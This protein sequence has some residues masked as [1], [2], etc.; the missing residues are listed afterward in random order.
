MIRLDRD[1]VGAN[2]RRSLH[3]LRLVHANQ[4]TQHGQSAGRFNDAQVLQGLRGHLPQRFPGHQRLCPGLLR[5]GQ[6]NT[7]HVAAIQHHPIRRRRHP[8]NLLLEVAKWHQKQACSVLVTRQPL[9][10]LARFLL[11]R[12]VQEGVTVK[13]H[14]IDPTAAFHHTI[15]GHRR[16]DATRQQAQHDT[17][18]AYRE[19]SRSRDFFDIHQGASWDD[20]DMHGEHRVIQRHACLMRGQDMCPKPLLEFH[21]AKR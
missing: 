1:W 13:V 3:D 2:A 16:I 4:G 12:A 15:G 14:E 10:E 20:I 18:D 8:D 17:A 6:R 9:R 7:Q 19:P 11:R 21:R 5:Q